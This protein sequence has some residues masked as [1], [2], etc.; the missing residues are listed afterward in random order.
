MKLFEVDRGSAILILR[1]LKR[2]A[3][4][5]R[6]SSSIPFSAIQNKL[7]AQGFGIDNPQ[8]LRQFLQSVD[9]DKNIVSQVDDQ[10]NVILN[11]KVPNPNKD[12]ALDTDTAPS[13]DQM[14]SSA[15]KTNPPK[16]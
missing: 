11:T 8:A 9:P 5:N 16:V 10:G 14:A 13:V 4:K 1:L 6:K 3:D 2:D 12:A 15:V 7:K